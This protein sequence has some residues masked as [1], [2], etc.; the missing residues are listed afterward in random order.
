[1]VVSPQSPGSGPAKRRVLVLDERP[2]MREVLRDVLEMSGCEVSEAA[3]LAKATGLVDAVDVVVVADVPSRMVTAALRAGTGRALRVVAV[4]SSCGQGRDCGA[5]DCLVGQ[6][7]AAEL[8]DAVLRRRDEAACGN[9]SRGL[10][11]EDDQA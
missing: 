11:S 10:P 6:F 1:M 7:S 4:C 8:A 3:S 9:R 5:D 2:G